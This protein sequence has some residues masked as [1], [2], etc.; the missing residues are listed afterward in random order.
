MPI[1]RDKPSNFDEKTENMPIQRDKPSNFGEKTEDTP[2]QRDKPSNLGVK[3]TIACSLLKYC[4]YR[5]NRYDFTMVHS[6]NVSPRAHHRAG[7]QRRLWSF[8]SRK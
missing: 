1:Q 7:G 4:R 6:G 2:T 3:T 5:A 8:K